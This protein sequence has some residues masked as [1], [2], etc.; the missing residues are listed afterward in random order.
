MTARTWRW[1]GPRHGGPR[2]YNPAM[3]PLM[4]AALP[5]TTTL[6]PTSADITALPPGL[7]DADAARISAAIAAA[8][9]ETTAPLRPGLERMGTL[10]R[11]SRHPG[12]AG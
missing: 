6:V 8:R 11:R 1:P 9:T 7:T 5:A 12:P 4:N 10:V 3:T 2:R